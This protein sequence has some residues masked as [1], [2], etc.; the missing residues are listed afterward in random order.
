MTTAT[1][2]RPLA[3]LCAACVA[4]APLLAAPAMAADSVKIGFVYFLSG[5]GAA[6]GSHARDA[7]ALMVDALNAGEVP[8]PYDTVGINGV[9]IEPIYIDEAGG[10]RKQI[11]EY[12][13]LVER[14]GVDMVLGYTSSSNCNAIA[15]IVEELETLTNFFHCGNPGLFEEVEPDPHYTFR[16]APMGTMD[17]VALARYIAD[18]Y[19]DTKT[20]SGVNQDYSWGQDNW[21]EFTAAMDALDTGA[22]FK[23]A[24]FPS[25]GAGDYG[26]EISALASDPADIT[27]V[28]F[29]GGDAD[30]LMLQSAA[31]GLGD[32]TRF[33]FT[34]GTGVIDG[35]GNNV[36]EGTIVGAR[37]PNS[38]LAKETALSSWFADAYQETYDRYPPLGAYVAAQGILAIK[39]AAE[40]A[41][42]GTGALPETDAII[43]ALEG[44]TYETVN[45]YPISMALHH[46]H[47]G[48][49]DTV[50][51]TYTGWD[52][53]A[54]APVIEDV[55]TYDAK[56][57][58]PPEGVKA[59]DWIESG[60]EG[61][62]C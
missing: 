36:I 11:A 32:S 38:Y 4:A 21:A 48:I 33:A 39:A 23:N 14:E 29:W 62:S 42:D 40:K 1:H 30:A 58:N 60:F 34:L 55:K 5:A 3:G 35:L 43:A 2:R 56:C 51:G 59:L 19:P 15:P 37:G 25:L 9:E 49:S 50:Y 46:G 20:V 52:D 12:R 45:G 10:V 7:A 44:L 54:N 18:V 26:S 31:R 17:Q 6:Y 28:S 16:S 27:F 8:A 41:A 24:L 61:A 47:Q 53:E 57:V 22:T 13:R